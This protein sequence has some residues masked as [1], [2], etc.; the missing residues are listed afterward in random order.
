MNGVRLAIPVA[1]V[2]ALVACAAMDRF[3]GGGPDVAPMHDLDTDH[4][5]FS[6]RHPVDAG[7]QD[8]AKGD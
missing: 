1:L 7:A 6:P 4:P 3:F 5:M 8:S 2:L